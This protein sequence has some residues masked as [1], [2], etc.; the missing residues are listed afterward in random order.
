MP[1][2]PEME[3]YRGHLG[4]WVSNRIIK[5][6]F[7]PRVKAINIPVEEF[8][9][10]VEGRMITNVRRRGKF[11]IF[12][13]DNGHYLLTHMML[14]GRL[15]YLPWEMARELTLDLNDAEAVKKQVTGIPAKPSVIFTLAD[16]AMESIL[17]FCQL[18]L[19]YL[20]YLDNAQLDEAL[21]DLGSDPLDPAFTQENFAGLLKGRRGMT[22]PWFMNQ[23]YIAGVGNAYSNETLFESGILPTRQIS[24]I[25]EDEIPKM[26]NSLVTILKESIKYGGD[27]EEPFAPWDRLT[28]GYNEH[29]RVYDREG[30]PCLV[31]GTNILKEEVGGRNAFYCPYCQH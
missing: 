6:V 17:F 13:L 18:T 4:Q 10:K 19:G 21:K 11:L 22:K 14:D 31:C 30:Q 5:Q 25:S 23:K 26:Y 1:E 2:I 8:T 24:N 12:D 28:G 3:I 29:F 16:G 15:Y 27:M 20:H 7:V 9:Q